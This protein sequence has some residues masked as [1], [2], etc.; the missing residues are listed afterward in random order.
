MNRE[1]NR[2]IRIQSTYNDL[3]GLYNLQDRCLLHRKIHTSG[4]CFWNCPITGAEMDI[5]RR[6]NIIFVTGRAKRDGDPVEE[7]VEF[8]S[9]LA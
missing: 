2:K 5:Y 1:I 4:V 6:N 9:L 3:Q 8:M 7:F